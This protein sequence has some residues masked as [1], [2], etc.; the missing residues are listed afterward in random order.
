M[1]YAKEA[2]FWGR[3]GEVVLPVCSIAPAP[4]PEKVRFTIIY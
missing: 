2:V 4:V 1:V 3:A